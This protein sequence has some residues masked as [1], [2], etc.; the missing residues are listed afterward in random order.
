VN[1]TLCDYT[2]N[3]TIFKKKGFKVFAMAEKSPGIPPKMKPQANRV[4]FSTTID[5][6]LLARLERVLQVHRAKTQTK[7]RLNDLLEEAI[8]LFLAQEEKK[9]HLVE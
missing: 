6:E 3:I 8:R 4:R 9:E 5:H 1:I 7:F 2:H